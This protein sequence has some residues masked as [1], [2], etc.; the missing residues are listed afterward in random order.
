V[1]LVAVDLVVQKFLLMAGPT[2]QRAPAVVVV[3]QAMVAAVA[4]EVL[5]L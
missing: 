4:P 2:E 3:V 5:E 1:V